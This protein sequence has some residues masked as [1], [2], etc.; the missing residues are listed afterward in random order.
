LFQKEKEDREIRG[1]T[2]ADGIKQR[3]FAQK[4]DS[5]NPTVFLE[6]IILTAIIEENETHD[7]AVIDIPNAFVQKEM[8]G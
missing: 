8:G 5:A 2:V 7:V 1:R 6:S 4:G 3:E